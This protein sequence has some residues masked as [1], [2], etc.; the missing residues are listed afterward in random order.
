MPRIRFTSD[1]KLPRDLA[2]L[3]YKKGDEVELSDNAAERWLRRGV[4]VVMPPGSRARGTPLRGP[5][6]SA[7][8]RTI[9]PAV[10]P[11]AAV[12]AEKPPVAPPAAAVAEKAA[13]PPTE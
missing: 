3:G 9:A 5:M 10:T 8:P 7:S 1:P 13:E 4:A 6:T 11:P 2:H 12:V